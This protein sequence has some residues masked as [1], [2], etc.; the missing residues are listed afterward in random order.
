MDTEIRIFPTPV[1]LAESL[2]VELVRIIKSHES[3]GAPVSIALSGGNTPELLFSIMGKNFSDSSFWKVVHFFWVDERC[4]PPE[5]TESNFG[6][7]KSALLDKILIPGTNIHRI[8]GEENPEKEAMRYSEE[9]SMFTMKKNG[10]PFFNIILLG[11]GED[12][13]TASI[14]PGNE[15][16]FSADEIC[17]VAKHPDTDRNRITLTGNVINN[18]ETVIFVV[19]GK[20]KSQMISNVLENRGGRIKVPASYVKPADG[21]L[22]WYLDSGAASKSD[23]LKLK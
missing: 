11:L 2:A 5:D 12:G 3:S 8:K 16:L 21:E 23:T 7:A 4:V 19:T 22:Y 13:H 15:R 1:L 6:M 17:A 10:W 18:A 9:I 20:G 14:F